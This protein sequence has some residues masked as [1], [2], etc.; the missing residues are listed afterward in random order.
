MATL[1]TAQQI[2]DAVSDRDLPSWGFFEI[3][4][5]APLVDGLKIAL[6]CLSAATEA[7][8]TR[9]DRPL[10]QLPREVRSRVRALLTRS[11]GPVSDS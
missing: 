11:L 5:L 7:I 1:A 10:F 9:S 3:H 8:R 4:H 2:F 6:K